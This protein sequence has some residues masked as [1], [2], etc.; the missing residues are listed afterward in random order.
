MFKKVLVPIDLSELDFC[1]RALD[2]GLR[3]VEQGAELHLIAV[4]PGFT[5]TMVASYFSEKEHKKAVSDVAEQL[6]EYAKDKLPESV[7]PI[8]RVHEGSPAES[9]VHYVDKLKINLV[10]MSAHNRSK[11]GEFF[12]GSVSA[13]VAERAKCSVLLLKD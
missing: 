7:K 11:M 12:L 1:Q 4:V 8:L 5:N 13:R 9:I 6:R 3:E 10:V 2:L